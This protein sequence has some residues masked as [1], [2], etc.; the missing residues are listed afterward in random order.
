MQC[1]PVRPL[2]PLPY[3]PLQSILI[4]Q[5]PRCLD[6]PLNDQSLSDRLSIVIDPIRK[7]MHMQMLFIGMF[8]KDILRIHHPDLFQVPLPQFYQP[9]IR[10]SFPRRK[11]EHGMIY[12]LFL[13]GH[14]PML[15]FEIDRHQPDI[16][17]P[18]SLRSQHLR[19]FVV[20]AEIG[21]AV[22][23]TLGCNKSLSDHHTKI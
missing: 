11:A 3:L 21:T 20:Q 2:Q 10:Y 17:R 8:D 19:S 9:L 16:M 6:S 1:L 5:F 18:N 13:L 15:A 14:Q 7:D 23:K 12:R 4:R 22:P